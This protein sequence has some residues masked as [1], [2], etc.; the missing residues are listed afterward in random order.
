MY[1]N[2]VLKQIRKFEAFQTQVDTKK[3]KFGRLL[4]LSVSK[5]FF[6]KM[7][8]KIKILEHFAV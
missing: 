2:L 6:I 5:F 8:V 4:F 7:H 1:L 3:S